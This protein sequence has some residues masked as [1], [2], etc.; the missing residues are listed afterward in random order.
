MMQAKCAEAGGP[1]TAAGWEI[2][3]RD[4]LTLWDLNGPTPAFADEV[5]TALTNNVLGVGDTAL[6]PGCGSGYDVVVL[7]NAGLRVTGCDIARA[8]VDRAQE[9]IAGSRNAD[10][11][12]A[13]FF[14]ESCF[15]SETFDF[16]F[17]YT[18]F[19]AIAPSQRAAWG[20]QIASLLKPGGRLLTFAFPIDDAKADDP[21]TSGPPH[22]VSLAAYRAALEPNAMSL[23][24]GP[25]RNEHSVRPT[26]MVIWWQKEMGEKG[27][28]RRIA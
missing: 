17:D 8:A 11:L 26:E 3:W 9:I 4:G 23:T 15:A 7:S 21:F 27:T 18:F 1:S 13:D 6:I 20:A 5:T 16:I 19:C 10:V 2:L 25:R 22:A 14:D 24:D 12:Y 28:S